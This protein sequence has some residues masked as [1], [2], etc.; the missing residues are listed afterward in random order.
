MGRE[1]SERDAVPL[2]MTKNDEN[3]NNCDDDMFSRHEHTNMSPMYSLNATG[4]DLGT[5][6]SSSRLRL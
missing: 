2:L 3:D 5:L 6:T 4:Y 1:D